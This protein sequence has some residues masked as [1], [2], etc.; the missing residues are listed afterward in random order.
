MKNN[1]RILI[2]A[3]GQ[4]VLNSKIGP[5]IDKFD[6][7]GRINNYKIDSY[8]KYL[9]KRTDIWINGANQKLLKRNQIFSQII[10]SI[11]SSIIIKKNDKLT[12]HVS[13]RLKMKAKEF[14]IIAIND[15]KRYEKTVGHKRLTT[16]ITSILWGLDH[17]EKVFIHGFD[18]FINSKSH[19]YDS[20]FHSFINQYLLNK[21]H[22][23]D[24]IK[25]QKFIQKLIN[26]GR[27]KKLVD[28]I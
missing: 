23:H 5:S 21:G 27:I 25:E 8:E 10:V 11:P 6:T 19:Y 3:N 28:N 22:K 20:K 15:I 14:S 7:I 9:G 24:N 2:I 17:F 26:N 4:S 1:K 16:G 13:K 12:E 18:F